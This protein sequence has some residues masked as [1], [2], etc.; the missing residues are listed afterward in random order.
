M[1]R[2]LAA[3][4]VCAMST[5]AVACTE[6]PTDINPDFAVGDRND[7]YSIQAGVVNVCAFPPYPSTINFTANFS[8]SRAPATGDLLSSFSL[9]NMPPHC[10]EV[11][12]ATSSTATTVTAALLSV[13]AG[14]VLDRIVTLTGD[15]ISDN[16]A[17]N[18]FGV[19]S[20]SVPAS[21]LVGSYIWFKFLEAEAPPPGGGQGC[22]P[23]YWRQSQHFGSWTGYTP[24]QAFSSV[25]A[26]AF[27]D[28][29]LLQ[30]VGL[31][32]GGINALGRHAVAALLNASSVD[33]DYDL[34]AQQVIDAF[35]AAY[36]SGNKN[37]IETQKNVFDLL[38]NQG[39]NL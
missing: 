4:V 27:P 30:V 16:D 9:T 13:P 6:G 25:F 12:N 22:T 21:D 38:N 8:A 33:V 35:N 3:A 14:V 5:F 31:G 11:W 28:K 26:D 19:M 36:A 39:C 15:G 2:P 23:G 32:G 7:M 34:S 37:V 10:I 1:N 17:V 29:T 18:H 20:A 24:D